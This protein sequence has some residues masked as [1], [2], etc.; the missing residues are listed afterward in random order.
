MP[1]GIASARNPSTLR[2]NRSRAAFTLPSGVFDVPEQMLGLRDHFHVAGAVGERQGAGE[3]GARA[4]EFSLRVPHHRRAEQ[5]SRLG[6][7]RKGR[8]V[9][10]LFIPLE[11]FGRVPPDQ[12]EVHQPP[13]DVGRFGG[14]AALD[15]PR[16]RAAVALEIVTHAIQPFDLRRSDQPLRGEGGFAVQ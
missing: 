9:Q 5:R 11:A 7:G 14:T 10:N 6:S 16:Q 3:P 15:E 13:R 1:H 8:Q 12:P 2:V 4:P